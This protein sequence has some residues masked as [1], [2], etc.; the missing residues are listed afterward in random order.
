MVASRTVLD[1]P[2]TQRSHASAWLPAPLTAWTGL[3]A[4]SHSL[5]AICAPGFHPMADGIADDIE[6]WEI[7]RTEP[8]RGKQALMERMQAMGDVSIA[9]D[10]HDDLVGGAGTALVG[11]RQRVHEDVQQRILR[12]PLLLSEQADR[13]AHVQ[14]A[15]DEC[16]FLR[17]VP[18]PGLGAGPHS[19]TVLARSIWS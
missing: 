12:Q 5:E 16:S 18:D 11:R 7:G 13:L 10:L 2:P 1:A 19:K 3:D 14:V 17:L 6:W 8:I 4:L 15:H 9:V